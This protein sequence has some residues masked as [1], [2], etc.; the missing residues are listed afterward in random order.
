MQ[1]KIT[2]ARKTENSSQ[3]LKRCHYH[4]G[5]IFIKASSHMA[6]NYS[7]QAPD[8]TAVSIFLLFSALEISCTAV[9]KVTLHYVYSGL[10]CELCFSAQPQLSALEGAEQSG[11]AAIA[12]K[13]NETSFA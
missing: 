3:G 13:D 10:C 4:D 5:I 9:Y 6:E 2:D 11:R 1:R 7:K 8:G 12:F